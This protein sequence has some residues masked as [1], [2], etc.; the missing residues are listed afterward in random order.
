MTP[1]E[2]FNKLTTNHGLSMAEIENIAKHTGNS[3]RSL[4]NQGTDYLLSVRDGL[5]SNAT[6]ANTPGAS[7]VPDTGFGSVYGYSPLDGIYSGNHGLGPEV[8]DPKYVPGDSLY[9]GF[10][11]PMAPK[12]AAGAPAQ[13]AQIQGGLGGLGGQAVNAYD[14]LN[15]WGQIAYG[16]GAS[17]SN[18]GF[19]AGYPTNMSPIYNPN[20]GGNQPRNGFGGPLGNNNPWSPTF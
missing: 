19:Q 6:A 18:N 10:T 3:M 2:Y 14:N 8:A 16:N 1:E 5:Q 11:D 12:G 4:A 15:Q 9:N 7:G 13:P 17:Q 20:P